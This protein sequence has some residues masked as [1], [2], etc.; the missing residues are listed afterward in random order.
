MKIF[1]ALYTRV[2]RWSRHRHA[3]Y[4]L[5][6]L[7]FVEA[8]VLPFPPPDVM[9]APM[10]LARPER[11]WWFAGMT[12]LTSVAGGLLGYVIGVY[13]FD[14]VAPL[15]REYGYWDRYLAA[16]SKF[17]EWGPWAVFVAGFSPIPYKIFTIGAGVMQ[18]SLL[19][20]VMAS[21][22]GRG[23][24]FYLVAALMVWG[25]AKME[26]RLRQYVDY[27]GWLLVCLVPAAYFLLRG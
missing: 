12:T 15:L 27:I 2:M 10:S 11:A 18:L 8:C 14:L 16:V 5:A 22:L 4:Y 26:N 20:F 23:A 25:G 13:F 17:S 7:S 19:P 9:L 3:P 1:S 21:V 6:G 24:R